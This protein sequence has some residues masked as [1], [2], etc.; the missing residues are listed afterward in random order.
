MAKCVID[1]YKYDVGMP[2]KV[3]VRSFY[4]LI[5]GI[6]VIGGFAFFLSLNTHKHI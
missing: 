5:M 6:M 4:T 2:H 1:D 3:V